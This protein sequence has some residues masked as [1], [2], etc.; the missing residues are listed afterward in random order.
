MSYCRGGPLWP[1]VKQIRRETGGH[2]GPPLQTMSVKCSSSFVSGFQSVHYFF[3]RDSLHNTILDLFISSL[4]F[5]SPQS[6]NSVPIFDVEPECFFVGPDCLV[7]F[8][9]LTRVRA[10]D[11]HASGTD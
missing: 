4:C 5:L 11:I 9:S 1:P 8:V 6:I 10:A 7:H 3:A 2:G